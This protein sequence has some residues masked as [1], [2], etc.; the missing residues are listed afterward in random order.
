MASRQAHGCAIRNV[1]EVTFEVRRRG[2]VWTVYKEGAFYGDFL[3]E[4]H[5]L[6][7]A[8]CAVAAILAAGGA[9]QLWVAAPVRF[10]GPERVTLVALDPAGCQQ[11][12]LYPIA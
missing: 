1:E 3:K 10:G 9:A 2:G 5:A 8:H 6:G 12:S 4:E 7:S 11:P